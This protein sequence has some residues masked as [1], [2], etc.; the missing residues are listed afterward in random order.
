MR[1]PSLVRIPRARVREFVNR[2]PTTA[3]KAG[4]IPFTGKIDLSPLWTP[5]RLFRQRSSEGVELSALPYTR[6]AC[7]WE[8]LQ[9]SHSTTAQIR[10]SEQRH[11]R[12][13]RSP[14]LSGKGTKILCCN[15]GHERLDGT[16]QD[17]AFIIREAPH[18]RF[19]RI[20]DDLYV[21]VRLPFIDDFQGAVWEHQRRGDKSRACLDRN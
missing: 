8:A 4:Y 10:D 9:V 2:D 15:V 20:D 21:D 14:W 7:S 16:R 1:S 13:R 17:L 11:S 19:L 18:D 5:T 12:L 3:D 6:G